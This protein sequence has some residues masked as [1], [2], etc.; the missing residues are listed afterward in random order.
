V[1]VL[2]NPDNA[3]NTQTTLRDVEA[4]ARAMGREIQVFN[5]GTSREVD[6]AL[7]SLVRGRRDALLVGGDTFFNSRRVQLALLAA[8]HAIPAT[9]ANR[10]YPTGRR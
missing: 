7:E 6:A 1:G 3:L 8:R 2:V 5:A 10:D 9:Y 4:A